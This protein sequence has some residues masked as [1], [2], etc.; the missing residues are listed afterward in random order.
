MK[1]KKKTES[2]V[3]DKVRFKNVI[4][5]PVHTDDRGDIYD[6]LEGADVDHIGMVTF[7]K[8]G[9]VRG[10]HY[11]LKSVQYSYVLEGRLLL[12]ISDPNGKRRS[13]RSSPVHSPQSHL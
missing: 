3:S 4:I 10:N 1:T 11:H 7:S 13:I 6:I 12:T 2:S 9:I 8:K 5:K